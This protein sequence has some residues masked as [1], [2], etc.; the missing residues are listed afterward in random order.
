M[1]E[2][3]VLV[4]T[5]G[6]TL[7]EVTPQRLVGPFLSKEN[8]EIFAGGVNPNGPYRQGAAVAVVMEA[9]SP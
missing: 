9:D 2:W 3:H 7:E 4:M 5:V 8:A 1:R 6:M